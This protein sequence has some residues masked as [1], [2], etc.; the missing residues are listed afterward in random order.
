M[1]LKASK[2]VTGT[3]AAL[4]ILGC[5]C[6]MRGGEGTIRIEEALR[7]AL[8][9]DESIAMQREAFAA[10]AASV[11]G[12]AGAYDPTLSAEAA[13]SE[14]RTPANSAFSGAPEGQLA[15]RHRATQATVGIE[16]L[17]PT[18][19]VVAVKATGDRGSTDGRFEPLSPAYQTRLGLE[20]RQ[21]L[22]RNRAIDAARAGRR[23]AESDRVGADAELRTTL[24]TTVAGVESVYWTLV[25]AHREIAVREEAVR[26]AEEQL[27]ET[28]VRIETGTAPETEI[29]Q[30]RAELERRQGELYASREAAVRAESGLK[31]LILGDAEPELWT[32]HLVPEESLEVVARPVDLAAAMGR[33]LEA[34]PELEV[35][36]AE[37]ERRRVE[38]ALARDAVR[39]SLDAIVVYDRFGLAG[40]ANPASA[41]EPIPAA[42]RGG[43]NDSLDGL[44]SNDFSD[45]KVGLRLSLPLGNRAARAGASVAA[46]AERQAAAAF[47]RA[48]KAIRAEVLDAAAALET[49]G[50]RIAAARAAREAAEVQLDSERIRYGSGLSTNF[51]VLT[52]QNDLS[53]ARLDEIAAQTDYRRA[54]TELARVTGTLLADRGVDVTADRTPEAR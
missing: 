43:L 11:E 31:R 21:P 35:F 24:A 51:L 52:R 38:S 44:A 45:T 14:A 33:A 42:L 12:A 36:A 17:L 8:E 37:L 48:R 32:E 47:A 30:P 3:L 7:M 29:S 28:Q 20:L 9:H 54:D 15:P 5:P 18:G 10:S 26:L 22:L 49:A 13:W 34:R 40:D 23:A 41:S 25:A 2:T 4:I 16:Q 19:G 27:A 53:R 39:P 50:Q 1:Q 46:S 6:E